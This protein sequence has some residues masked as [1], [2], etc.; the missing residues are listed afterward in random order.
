VRSTAVTLATRA[1]ATEN[2]ALPIALP[3]SE[4][5]RTP[6]VPGARKG[7]KRPVDVWSRYA[8]AEEVV[9]TPAVLE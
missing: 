5:Y 1:L 3:L 7:A 9:V 6:D 2:A 4:A 8:C